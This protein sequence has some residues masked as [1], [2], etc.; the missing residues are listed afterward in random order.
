[1]I[2]EIQPL[3]AGRCLTVYLTVVDQKEGKLQ[4]TPRM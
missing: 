1:M 4:I 3:K 2:T